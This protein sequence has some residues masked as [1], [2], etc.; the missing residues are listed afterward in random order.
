VFNDA[1]FFSM[2]IASRRAWAL[3]VDLAVS[4]EAGAFAEVVGGGY[5]SS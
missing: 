4:Q 5:V 3:L 2:G 1:S